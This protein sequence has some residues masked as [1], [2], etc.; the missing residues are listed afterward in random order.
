MK[1]SNEK[2][3]KNLLSDIEALVT[4]HIYAR[5]LKANKYLEKLLIGHIS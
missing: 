2:Q 1:K 3:V 5:D 4:A